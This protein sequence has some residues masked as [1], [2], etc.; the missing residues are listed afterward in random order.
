M[1]TTRSLSFVSAYGKT[2]GQRMDASEKIDI[3]NILK[4]REVF[5]RFRKDMITERD[6]TLVQASPHFKPK[7]EN[8]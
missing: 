1:Y 7:E 5:K 3:S 2:R 8:F 4:A 6:L